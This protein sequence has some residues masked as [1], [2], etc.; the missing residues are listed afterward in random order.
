MIITFTFMIHYVVT[1]Q[2]NGAGNMYM[3]YITILSKSTYLTCIHTCYTL[4]IENTIVI[5]I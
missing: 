3:L 2:I 4:L 5:Y 1:L